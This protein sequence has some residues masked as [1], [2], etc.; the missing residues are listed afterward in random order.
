MRGQVRERGGKPKPSS[1]DTQML[2]LGVERFAVPE[3]LF[4]PSDVEIGQMGL[5]EAMATSLGRLPKGAD[6][7]R[8][9]GVSHFWR[10]LNLFLR[11]LSGFGGFQRIL[12]LFLNFDA[13]S[14]RLR[15]VLGDFEDFE[16]IFKYFEGI[17]GSS[18]SILM[19]FIKFGTFST[20]LRFNKRC[21]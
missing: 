21:F 1:N 19:L 5:V 8:I 3:L 10:I 6:S 7:E 9:L 12:R 4:H 17:F 11:L 15:G 13:F 20:I 18:S 16:G 14:R 2:S